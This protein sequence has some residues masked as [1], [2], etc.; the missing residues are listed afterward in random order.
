MPVFCCCLGSRAKVTEHK[1]DLILDAHVRERLEDVI[2]VLEDKLVQCH[3]A[4]KCHLSLLGVM[5]KV[6]FNID[7]E[8]CLSFAGSAKGK[9]AALIDLLEG[10][11]GVD[12]RLVLQEEVIHGYLLRR[13]IYHL[14]LTN[15]G[16]LITDLLSLSDSTLLAR[17]RIIE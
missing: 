7:R 4:G 14:G 15:V 8:T 6:E 2:I 11:I 10:V 16:S 17:Y 5:E 9:E 1:E 12:L 3:L 13:P